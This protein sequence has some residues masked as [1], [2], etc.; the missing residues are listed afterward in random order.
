LLLAR[1]L[2]QYDIIHFNFGHTFMPGRRFSGNGTRGE[3]FR[4]CYASLLELGDL[5]LLKRAGKGI[6]VTFQGDDARQGSAF[7]RHT[8][9][10]LSRE[11]EPGYYNAASDEHKRRRIEQIARYADCIYA[12]NPDLFHV[13]PRWA[14]FV[15]YAHV[16]LQEW[17]ACP[18]QHD[19]PRPPVVA[20]APTHRGIKGTRFVLDAIQRLKAEGMAIDFRLV[21]NHTWAEARRLYQQA[22]VLIDQLLLGWYG[23]LAVELMA[24]GKPVICHLRQ[25]DFGVLPEEMR[26]QLPLIN[27][28]PESL[29]RVLKE[30]LTVRR[31]ELPEV[32]RRGRQF[33]ERWHDPRSI[34]RQ[35]IADYQRIAAP[36]HWAA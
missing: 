13:L 16:D 34:A 26:C 1:G 28:T 12:L 7:C 8:G 20:H 36:R 35:M 31:A 27:A 10:D 21:E 24:L 22:D 4:N 18:P 17:Q 5:P 30:W 29:Y 6:V 19:P 2:L 9:F 14:K 23:G 3:W 25:E 32:G 11:L 15:P 33:V